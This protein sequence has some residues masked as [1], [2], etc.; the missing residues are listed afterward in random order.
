MLLAWLSVMPAMAQNDGL[1]LAI[2]EATGAWTAAQAK[3]AE[4]FVDAQLQA[5]QGDS[6][7]TI[8]EARDTLR[9]PLNDLRA[10]NAFQS[11][12]FRLLS[13]RMQAALE[14]A[15]IIGKIN[16]MMLARNVVEPGI[17]R[18]L[19]AGLKEDSA[20]VRFAAAKSLGEM[21]PN[22][23]LGL[24][25]RE[26]ERLVG[27]LGQA[28]GTE[29]DAFAAG[30]MLDAMRAPAL[31]STR[32]MLL[33]VF[34]QRVVLH[35]ADAT[36]SYQPELSAMQDVFIKGLGGFKRDEAKVFMQAANRYLRLISVQMKAG[37]VPEGNQDAAKRL[38]NQAATILEELSRSVN[39][40]G[41]MP[42]GV[43]RP[44]AV[45][46]WDEIIGI[47]DQWSERMGGPP[48]N[49]SA[50]DLSIDAPD[51]PDA[52]EGEEAADAEVVAEQ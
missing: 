13:A 4:A 36:L 43:A 37:V 25:D 2:L 3:E 22:S 14:K 15:S 34:N 46:A 48:L 8:S 31:T 5:F 26:K 30:K 10:G 9:K 28:A 35:A 44:L 52:P 40:P 41:Q 42:G 23:A 33:D 45:P 29:T 7:E 50:D 51:A 39:L 18:V 49:L 24:S 1:D 32:P 11:Q 16:V 21:M 38:V 12:Y 17:V 27:V 6:A 19:E 47:G 20:G